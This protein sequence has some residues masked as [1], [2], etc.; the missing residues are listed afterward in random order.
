MEEEALIIASS[1][2]GSTR[3]FEM[4][5]TCFST[6]SYIGF[7]LFRSCFLFRFADVDVAK[8]SQILLKPI[9]PMTEISSVL[10]IPHNR[11]IL[12]KDSREVDNF[13][14][15]YQHEG[16][17]HRKDIIDCLAHFIWTVDGVG[18]A[19]LCFSTW[20]MNHG[21]TGRGE[22]IRFFKND[23]GVIV[24]ETVKD[25]KKGDELLNDYRDFDPMP[26]FW[27]NY[28]KK[29]GVK[30]VLTNLKENVDL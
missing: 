17:Q 5:P 12:F 8:G 7:C 11:V 24:G 14:D 20:T 30:D 21:D 15:L 27:V 18:G 13:I 23:D 9:I 25:V 29:E 28:C 3:L 6:T 16:N 22:N 10:S 4:I 26:K 1:H 19:T 2:R